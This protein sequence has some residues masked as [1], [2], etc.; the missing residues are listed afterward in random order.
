[1]RAC[2]LGTWHLGS[3][4]SACLAE[5]GHTV[6]G[7][8]PSRQRVED[9]NRGVPPLY[10]PGLEELLARN[11]TAR[12]LRYTTD[13]RA[14]A[15]DA[16][17]VII[18]YDTPVNDQDEVDLTGILAAAQAVAPHLD[19]GAT[20]IVSSQVPVGTCERLADAVRRA[21]PDLAFGIACLP[22]NLRLGQAVQRFLAP[23]FLVIGA[24]DAAVQER[25]EA[26]LA[27]IDAPKLRVGLRT[28]EMTKHAINAYLATSISL[29]NE[30]ANLCDLVGA[31]AFQVAE[32]L[33]LDSRIGPGAPL[34]PGLGFGGGTLARDLQ[35]LSRL[36]KD[37][38]YEPH[39]IDG[40]LAVNRRQ[41][42]R[43]LSRL[44]GHYRSLHGLTVGVLG[45]TYKPETSTLRRSP[46]LEMIRALTAEGAAVKVY[47]PRADAREVEQHRHLF[48]RYGDPYAVAEGSQA[49]ILA[50]GW[51]QFKEL[52]FRRIRSLVAN[53][54]FL[55]AQN[56]LD[57]D[58]M[59]RL[60]FIYQGVGRARPRAR[61][62]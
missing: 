51:P 36:G 45:L 1:M 46:S 48:A 43:I 29:I 56:M 30:I 6:I 8:D 4:T 19:Q 2:V 25:V 52:D 24:E 34:T 20:L 49:L 23:E 60:G 55:D 33:R 10:E 61:T 62:P 9:L 26:L 27:R 16:E 59:S 40:V 47:D 31:D 18:A 7:M 17:S 11:L 41:N 50:T 13:L 22:E 5:L 54:L 38:A 15:R 14:A 42:E 44:K 58:K 32:A 12:R 28:A 21:N 37:N 3:V 35:V 53:P 39:L 57:P